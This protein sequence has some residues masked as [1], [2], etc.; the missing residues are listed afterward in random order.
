MKSVE[1]YFSPTFVYK[2]MFPHNSEYVSCSDPDLVSGAECD[3]D[4]PTEH[5]EKV[6]MPG[7][8]HAPGAELA[9]GK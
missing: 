2:L 3:S 5:R 8:C 4:G 7:P 1:Q 9:R 6:R